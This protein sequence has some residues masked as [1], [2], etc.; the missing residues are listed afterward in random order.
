[1]WECLTDVSRVNNCL[2]N[3]DLRLAINARDDLAAMVILQYFFTSKAVNYSFIFSGSCRLSKI[4]VMTIISP[5]RISSTD[6]I[7]EASLHPGLNGQ[8]AAHRDHP[9][10]LVIADDSRV[11]RQIVI[12]TLRLPRTLAAAEVGIAFGISGALFQAL[13]RNP[14]ASPDIIGV[15]QVVD[16]VEVIE[17]ADV[18]EIVGVGV[19]VEVV[20][21]GV[22]HDRVARDGADRRHQAVGCRDVVLGVDRRPGGEDGVGQCGI[23]GDGQQLDTVIAPGDG[24]VLQIL[25]QLGVLIM[26]KKRKPAKPALLIQTFSGLRFGGGGML[27]STMRVYGKNGRRKN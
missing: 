3:F 5:W 27:F 26:R 15:I 21:V 7:H 23:A 2:P 13:A 16:S 22:E 25:D 4:S 10:Q 14:L 11:M 17:I 24:A 20:G 8:Q 9:D 12:R 6:H 1:M 18:V 19:H